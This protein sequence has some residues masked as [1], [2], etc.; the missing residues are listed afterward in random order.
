MKIFKYIATSLLFI[1]VVGCQQAPEQAVISGNIGYLERIALLPNSQ[2]TISLYDVSIA[3]KKSE[4]ITEQTIDLKDKQVP[5]AFK[6]EFEA[7]KLKE[8]G[9][10]AIRAII[11]SQQGQLLWTTDTNYPVESTTSEQK[12]GMLRLVK[13]KS[14]EQS[15]TSTSITDLTQYQC[16]ELSV[17]SRLR[18]NQLEL[19][20]NGKS[21]LLNR[22]V[23]ASG[24]KYQLDSAG[25]PAIDFWQK[26]DEAMLTIDGETLSCQ[27]EEQSHSD[28]KLANTQWQVTQINNQALIE[29]SKVTINFSEQKIYGSAGCNQYTA[30]YQ[31]NSPEIKLSTIAVTKKACMAAELAEQESRFLILL[32]E[33]KQFTTGNNNLTLLDGSGN[34]LIAE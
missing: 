7:D 10:Y 15:H 16:D 23:A 3:D 31:L 24:E 28:N 19:I 34:K 1:F 32:G 30:D 2:A 9:R 25:Q 4:L 14:P 22:V 27:S 17:Q 26:G 20:F 6:L 21:Y 8:N 33:V 5:I 29:N 11:K 13:V 18:D 12:L